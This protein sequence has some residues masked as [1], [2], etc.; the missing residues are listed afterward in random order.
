LTFEDAIRKGIEIVS[1]LN[2]FIVNILAILITVTLTLVMRNMIITSTATAVSLNRYSIRYN[3]LM[4]NIHSLHEYLLI[5]IGLNEG[6]T[7]KNRYTSL[8]ISADNPLYS[9]FI[10][11]SRID[12]FEQYSN[13]K[14]AEMWT[15]LDTSMKEFLKKDNYAQSFFKLFFDQRATFVMELTSDVS[16]TFEV[17]MSEYAAFMLLVRTGSYNVTN[18]GDLSL[19]KSTTDW[20]ELN[21]LFRNTLNRF[22][23]TL[24]GLDTSI[25][26]MIEDSLN[27]LKLKVFIILYINITL[28]AVS[29]IFSIYFLIKILRKFR[30]IFQ[31]IEDIRQPQMEERMAHLVYVMTLMER[32][33]LRPSMISLAR[34]PR[35]ED[36]EQNKERYKASSEV[37]ARLKSAANAKSGSNHPTAKQNHMQMKKRSTMQLTSRKLYFFTLLTS[38]IVLGLFYCGQFVFSGIIVTSFVGK[39]TKIHSINDQEFKIQELNKL[40]QEYRNALLQY[41]VLGRDVET[42]KNYLERFNALETADKSDLTTRITHLEVPTALS[43]KGR[44]AEIKRVFEAVMYSNLCDTLDNLK[45]YRFL[46][47]IVDVQI[48]QKG[49]LQAYFRVKSFFGLMMSY[50]NSPTDSQSFLKSPEYLNFEFAYQNIYSPAGLFIMNYF[51]ENVEA[52]FLEEVLNVQTMIAISVAVLIL[53][54]S[55]FTILTFKDIF[56][57]K[58][59]LSFVFQVCPLE[60]MVDNQRIRVLF[61]RLFKLDNQ[62]FS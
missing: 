20:V 61:L 12:D 14:I 39:I 3:N 32:P 59:E 25:K 51:A 57:V 23:I 7:D 58:R 9:S 10:S 56:K 50:I 41:S 35:D 60:G 19:I 16:K 1:I 34:K 44:D 42:E 11:T 33:Y 15:R 29:L 37:K 8:K 24:D 45:Q 26:S 5:R 2:L 48:P 18:S 4:H 21:Y 53:F 22:L 17:K 6:S 54:S 55:T 38:I 43:N 46:C 40:L 13:I 28:V 30:S 27:S 62:Y 36:V 52:Y 47:D 31:C 49:L